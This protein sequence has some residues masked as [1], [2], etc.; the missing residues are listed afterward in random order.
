[1]ADS[2]ASDFSPFLEVRI[3]ATCHRCWVWAERRWAAIQGLRA[4]GR[5]FPPAVHQGGARSAAPTTGARSPF[6]DRTAHRPTPG[7]TPTPTPASGQLNQAGPHTRRAFRSDGQCASCGRTLLNSTRRRP[8]HRPNLLR[9]PVRMS[10]ACGHDQLLHMRLKG[11]GMSSRRTQTLD[12]R[13]QKALL[14]ALPQARLS[15]SRLIG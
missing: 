5:A 7:P 13:P 11:V 12:Q 15:G 6:A 3:P 9:T 2:L 1:M 14:P 4:G 10:R 8:R